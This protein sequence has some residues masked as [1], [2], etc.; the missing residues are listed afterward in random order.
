MRERMPTDKDRV[1]SVFPSDVEIELGGNSYA[2]SPPNLNILADLEEHFNVPFTELQ[3]LLAPGRPG[4]FKNVRYILYRMLLE[5]NPGLKGKEL[6]IGAQCN[7]G[8]LP[9]IMSA[10]LQA[11]QKGLPEGEAQTMVPNFSPTP[12]AE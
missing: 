12:E 11:F 5:S 10:I 9:T 4:M 1:S 8:N 3:E 2:I 6:E 7:M